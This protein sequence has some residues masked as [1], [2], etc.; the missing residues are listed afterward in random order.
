VDGYVQFTVKGAA[1][2]KYVTVVPYTGA[3]AE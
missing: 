1:Q 2:R 3:D